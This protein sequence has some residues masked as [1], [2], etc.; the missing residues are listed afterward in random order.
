MMQRGANCCERMDAHYAVGETKTKE[1]PADATPSA[2]RA[3]VEALAA[4]GETK[5]EEPHADAA[6]APPAVALAQP[7]TRVAHRDQRTL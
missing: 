6:A 4:V 5:T 7:E 3:E 1:P 2:D